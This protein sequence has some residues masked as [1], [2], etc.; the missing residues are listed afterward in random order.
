MCTRLLRLRAERQDRRQ[1]VELLYRQHSV[2]LACRVERM[3]Y[4]GSGVYNVS[5]FGAALTSQGL[6]P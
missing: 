4:V 2:L 5:V 1:A 3:V 6:R